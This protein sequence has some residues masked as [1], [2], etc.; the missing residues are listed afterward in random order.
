MTIFERGSIPPASRTL[1]S[2]DTIHMILDY[3]IAI[4]DVEHHFLFVRT[5]ASPMMPM[6]IM[7]STAKE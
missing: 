5:L 4:S 7:Q 6:M 2:D 3:R 1:V